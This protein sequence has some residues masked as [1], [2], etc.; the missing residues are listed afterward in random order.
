[1]TYPASF[2][3]IAANLDYATGAK[4]DARHLR[5]LLEQP[6]RAVVIG[7]QE[8]KNVRLAD[9]AVA[10]A[11]AYQRTQT[12]ARRGSGFVTRGIKVRRFRLFLGGVSAVTL[13]RH[14]ARGRIRLAGGPA[15]VFSAH[16][17]PKRGGQAA[18]DRYLRALKRRTD[19]LSRKGVE[20]VVFIDANRDV[21][22]VARYLGG[23]VAA[24]AKGDRIVGVII[25]PGLRVLAHGVDRYGRQ[26]GLTDHLCPYAHIGMKGSAH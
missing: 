26:N 1:M 3:G 19:R 9:V 8:A 21:D 4:A 10:P 12:A 24:S 16:A 15:V 14:V 25:S 23:R 2:V 18:Q 13:P 20:W 7:V 17:P 22:D 11:R 6:A 5:H